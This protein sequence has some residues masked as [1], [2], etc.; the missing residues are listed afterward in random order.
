MK[1]KSG[2]VVEIFIS[3]QINLQQSIV[4][5][6]SITVRGRTS[7]SLSVITGANSDFAFSIDVPQN[8]IVKL[9]RLHFY[10]TSSG[11]IQVNGTTTNRGSIELKDVW[12]SESK[13]QDGG[14]VELNNVVAVVEG[15]TFSRNQTSNPAADPAGVALLVRDTDLQL[16]NSTFYDNEIAYDD[17]FSIGQG[18]DVAAALTIIGSSDVRLVHNS[19]LQSRLRGDSFSKWYHL[20]IEATATVAIGNS[21]LFQQ[22]ESSENA[23]VIGSYED[24]GGNYIDETLPISEVT[25][26]DFFGGYTPT[27][28]PKA[29]SPLVD[30]GLNL[31]QLPLTDQRGRDR[32]FGSAPDIGAGEYHTLP[33]I[34]YVDR[35]AFNTANTGESW[36]NA[37]TRLQT[38]LKIAEPGTEI[39]VAQGDYIGGEAPAPVSGD[40]FSLSTSGVTLIGS[41][42]TGA[43]SVEEQNIIEFTTTLLASNET[44]GASLT[45]NAD[46]IE[47]NGFVLDQVG[48]TT[49]TDEKGL[50]VYN[51]G[52]EPVRIFNVESNVTTEF[53]G[54]IV[55]ENVLT[56]GESILLIQPGQEVTLINSTLLATP[57]INATGS[58]LNIY[59]S[60]INGSVTGGLN[61]V[62]NSIFTQSAVTINA[63]NQDNLFGENEGDIFPTEGPALSPGSVAVGFGNNSFSSLSTDLFGQERIQGASVDAGAFELSGLQQNL[64]INIPFESGEGI[65]ATDLVTET[66][67]SNSSVVQDFNIRTGFGAAAGFSFGSLL[68][69]N[70]LNVPAAETTVAFWFRPDVISSADK[71]ILSF[72]N[73]SGNSTFR[74]GYYDN[75]FPQ[76][77]IGDESGLRPFEADYRQ[78]GWQHVVALL[79]TDGDYAVY[80]NNELVETD[81]DTDLTLQSRLVLGSSLFA[82][83]IDDFRVYDKQLTEQEIADLY[84][85][86]RSPA[87]F[88]LISAKETAE[89]GV[90]L[91]W[92]RSA[93]ALGYN[94]YTGDYY[95]PQL[96]T[97]IS[98]TATSIELPDAN[99]SAEYSVGSFNNYGTY[100]PFS[101]VSVTPYIDTTPGVAKNFAY[102]FDEEDRFILLESDFNEGLTVLDGL[103]EYSMEGWFQF[104]NLSEQVNLFSFKQLNGTEYFNLS[105]LSGNVVASWNDGTTTAS[106]LPPAGFT[107]FTG[108][109]Y[110]ISLSVNGTNANLY[111]NGINFGTQPAVALPI[112]L[113]SGQSNQFYIGGQSSSPSRV[114]P[115]LADE[116]RVFSQ[117]LTQEQVRDWLAR[118]YTDSHPAHANLISAYTFDSFEERFEFGSNIYYL[119]DVEENV[120]QFFSEGQLLVLSQFPIG[121][122][123]T[124]VD[125][126]ASGSASTFLNIG[127]NTIELTANAA[128]AG[129]AAT[130]WLYGN[131]NTLAYTVQAV[132]G[133]LQ[134]EPHVGVF[135]NNIP[136][137]NYDLDW[138]VSTESPVAG[139]SLVLLQQDGPSFTWFK[140]EGAVASVN[141]ISSTDF[142]DNKNFALGTTVATGEAGSAVAFSGSSLNQ[143]VFPD[144]AA[145]EPG[146]KDHFVV[147]LWFSHS[148]NGTLLS[149]LDGANG[150]SIGINEAERL[151]LSFGN[152]SD[153]VSAVGESEIANFDYHNL[154]LYVTRNGSELFADVYLNGYKEIALQLA[155]IDV[156]AATAFTIG[157]SFGGAID[158]LRFYAPATLTAAQLDAYVANAQTSVP[159]MQSYWEGLPA[160]ERLAYYNFN[161]TAG[162]FFDENPVIATEGGIDGTPAGFVNSAP[163]LVASEAGTTPAPRAYATYNYGTQ[164]VELIFGPELIFPAGL[165]PE[166]YQIVDFLTEELV[167][168]T[169]PFSLAP[170]TYGYIVGVP[171]GYSTTVAFSVP[172]TIAGNAVRFYNEFS[173]DHYGLAEMSSIEINDRFTIDFWVKPLSLSGSSTIFYTENTEISIDENGSL[174]ASFSDALIQTG[175]AVPTNAWQHVALVRE[176]NQ[177]R[178]YLNGEEVGVASIVEATTVPAP[179]FVVG[180]GGYID[181]EEDLITE[182]Y[183]NGE[184]DNLRFWNDNLDFAGTDN[185]LINSPTNFGEPGLVS[186][187]KFDE[188]SDSPI[189][190]D[191]NFVALDGNPVQRFLQLQNYNYPPCGECS[192]EP[193]FVPS[194]IYAA[195]GPAQG[196]AV[197]RNNQLEL[198]FSAVAGAE[199]YNIYRIN[200]AGGF[201]QIAT[202]SSTSFRDAPLANGSLIQY[203]VTA[204]VGGEETAASPIITGVPGQGDGNALYFDGNDD[205]AEGTGFAVGEEFTIE[206]WVQTDAPS[207]GSSTIFSW[208]NGS[209]EGLSLSIT[210]N[211]ALRLYS[212]VGGEGNT[213]STEDDIVN[214]RWCHIA[215]R[216][217]NSM[218]EVLLNE[219]VVLE[220]SVSVDIP[221]VNIPFALSKGIPTEMTVDELRLWSSYRTDAELADY[222][223]LAARGDEANLLGL[224]HFNEP[225]DTPIAYNSA[226]GTSNLTL[227]GY[228]FED[229]NE[230]T[231]FTESYAFESAP[232][233]IENFTPQS[234][235]AGELITINGRFNP[236]QPNSPSHEIS[237]AGI[238]QAA[239]TVTTDK[240]TVRVPAGAP[241][242]PLQLLQDD[243]KI[244]AT[245]AFYTPEYIAIDPLQFAREATNFTDY[246]TQSAELYDFDGDGQLDWISA[247]SEEGTTNIN[248]NTNMLSYEGEGDFGEG[249]IDGEGPIF[250]G[251]NPFLP[252]N[253]FGG[254]FSVSGDLLSDIRFVQLNKVR[255]NLYLVTTSGLFLYEALPGGDAEDT[256]YEPIISEGFP[257]TG[258]T[259]ALFLELDS[260]YTKPEL[261]VINEGDV[262]LWAYGS[263]SYFELIETVP[264]I[265]GDSFKLVPGLT[266]VASLQLEGDA[267][268]LHAYQGNGTFAEPVQVFSASNIINY[269]FADT[270]ADGENE[271]FVVTENEEGDLILTAYRLSAGSYSA[272]FS[273]PVA[274]ENFA[275]ADFDA[276]AEMDIVFQPDEGDLQIV[277]SG[278][279]YD[280]EAAVVV[281]PV[282][283]DFPLVADFNADGN[284][285]ISFINKSTQ[286]M[287]VW[288]Q[289]E[290]PFGLVDL[291]VPEAGIYTAGE[292]L[293]YELV[294]SDVPVVQGSPKVELRI[295]GSEDEYL[296][297]IDPQVSGNSVFFTLTVPESEVIQLDNVLI[298]YVSILTEEGTIESTDGEEAE[299]DIS[300]TDEDV[301]I[302]NFEPTPNLTRI[303]NW[304]FNGTE[305][306]FSAE[307]NSTTS[308]K[309]FTLFVGDVE[310]NQEVATVTR[311]D[312]SEACL[313]N[314]NINAP[315][316]EGNYSYFVTVTDEAGNVS[317]PSAVELVTID[318]TAPVV[319]S[320]EL[321]GSPDADEQIVYFNLIANEDL[322]NFFENS[323]SVEVLDGVV[324]AAIINNTFN[325][326][327]QAVEFEVEVTSGFGEM[328][329][330]VVGSITDL[331]G[332]STEIDVQSEVHSVS[333]NILTIK[334]GSLTS[335]FVAN[336]A[337]KSI[338]GFNIRSNL[339]VAAE[340]QSFTIPIASPSTVKS[341][342][343]FNLQF[344]SGSLA[345][346][347]TP[348]VTTTT[349]ANGFITS[350][351]VDLSSS[352]LTIPGISASPN[353]FLSVSLIVDANSIMDGKTLTVGTPTLSDFDITSSAPAF[354]EVEVDFENFR[355]TLNFFTPGSLNLITARPSDGADNVN[356]FTSIVLEFNQ[357]V[358]LGTI[359]AVTL[360][361]STGTP[362][363]FNA[364]SS[365]N[366]VTLR[367][368][369][370]LD[371]ATE[372]LI[373]IDDDPTTGLKAISGDLYGGAN[374]TFTT[375]AVPSTGET[376]VA[377]TLSSPPPLP[378]Y[379][380]NAVA[381][382]DINNDDYTRYSSRQCQP[383]GVLARAGRW[384]FCR[385]S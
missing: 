121:I 140:V 290:P 342:S 87:E 265:N 62:S 359:G 70:G 184:L 134:N 362:L 274:T 313:V 286:K 107:F 130:Y 358:D 123:A 178:L 190:T 7:S 270:D 179:Y 106:W 349:D 356:P 36:A 71:R 127:T 109:R 323:S 243:G 55:L 314:I 363:G 292:E 309:T 113:T 58:N 282:V 68:T 302:D 238:L 128:S 278:D 21:A 177:L 151:Q 63:T 30:T 101:S 255:S 375:G 81:N 216:S 139:E 185:V 105:V 92:E 217:D 29:G 350:L 277:R 166:D 44:G 88:D 35:N 239:T 287:E 124:Y 294:F 353:N 15:S 183:F 364:T 108:L 79:D 160:A 252:I 64:L 60:I 341:I 318:R 75:P 76:L 89:G 208:L 227:F 56:D 206:F 1:R 162:D 368:D 126:P 354:T 293:V 347:P 148:F 336:N 247:S 259:E 376:L 147:S 268:Q 195:P 371:P 326:G 328:A 280:Q 296:Y 82:G 66:D 297:A 17:D 39:W 291:I 321:S 114:A 26:S 31:A 300:P 298:L 285:D 80:F 322:S 152:G 86:F 94:I 196:I 33:E 211:N 301:R 171:D 187:Y 77:Y 112:S 50:G 307:T 215:I 361:S 144:N 42:P 303:S 110:H 331:A 288:L 57:S 258:V 156:S 228:D 165:S 115:Q 170:G 18:S 181:E 117:A 84:Q 366:Q 54:N 283:A 192:S 250:G 209:N 13:N 306:E 90:A 194:T 267:I 43:T 37:Y 95:S 346:D 136:E 180:A 11:A 122:T 289:Q 214:F 311:S 164:Q 146:N 67:P 234:A 5:D 2:D 157:N 261:L 20:Y 52:T 120:R 213:I 269:Q 176:L 275:L 47:L 198:I 369:N 308:A 223:Y 224:Y 344:G 111:V 212:S 125:A 222:R 218:L 232:L 83:A 335:G 96:L 197:A 91:E 276:D 304:Y 334:P 27:I 310:D 272:F 339:P 279:G 174:I 12:V 143:I 273:S 100:E 229:E 9:E 271:L 245:S 131:T 260:R 370:P 10:Q 59:N 325:N 381:T 150:Y 93:G 253:G 237:F 25:V 103:S 145:F 327:D 85:S 40:A 142:T 78:G 163:D 138:S 158:E 379:T 231:D 338:A 132:G 242:G 281:A 382:G 284:A 351:T 24:L 173:D 343:G 319:Q 4:I 374:I 257:T 367:P 102:N 262:E 6:K 324:D 48:G 186:I 219:D 263:S 168:G 49:S 357:E 116:V 65:S 159:N 236:D 305:L 199:Q 97:S 348:T 137:I 315:T 118:I 99:P 32:T 34:V 233:V 256:Q 246:T 153:I 51:S 19:F 28:L 352:P 45:I 167:T 220:Q 189:F 119:S 172:A 244:T 191:N 16:Y 8:G 316:Q 74:I 53:V 317:A 3:S 69:Y 249:P 221:E 333:L 312:C 330:S 266:G 254:S 360:T 205:Y 225:N 373:D 182:N 355:N 149:K 337:T 329:V 14:V 141:A 129:E 161:Q 340:L 295:Y 248:I 22:V 320:F 210:D 61:N 204:V 154:V 155:D 240:I 169:P 384:K 377:N 241:Y 226:N 230:D 72:E 23:A 264:N 378:S 299:F 41:L 235:A 188:D 380:K 201:T 46:N 193:P 175:I 251:E 332:N 202:T 345:I 200:N 38:A 104:D 133:I 207:E 372:Y 385:A 203:Y 365:S 98:S 135:C 383:N 73:S